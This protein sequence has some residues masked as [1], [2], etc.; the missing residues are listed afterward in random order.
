M[1]KQGNHTR[2]LARCFAQMLYECVVHQVTVVGG[3]ANRMA[4]QKAGQ[5][6][7]ASYGMSTVQFW[8]DRMEL[9]MDSYF[10]TLFPDTVR[11]LKHSI[12]FLDLLELREKLEGIVDVDPQVRQ[13]TQY[14]GDC[15][16]LTFFE[17]GLSMQK[18]GFH[19]KD[20]AGQL[21]YRY[22]V[23]VN[24]KLIHL[25]ND[26]LLLREKETDSHCPIL[27]T[28][29]PSDMTNQ[30]KKSFGSEEARKNRADKRKAEQK[31]RKAKGKARQ[32]QTRC[33]RYTFHQRR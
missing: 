22:S 17:L 15:C 27:V 7:N 11:D 6:L 4:Y 33:L 16:T 23:N 12:S 24:E 2:L 26:I 28:I 29:E 25:T 18:D 14:I 21:E 32:G 30:E 9:T 13:E 3:D 5:Q 8:L 19:D 1:L 10:K 20:Q 31:A